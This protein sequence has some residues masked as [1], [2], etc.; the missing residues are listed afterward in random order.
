MQA[1]IEAV[2]GAIVVFGPALVCWILVRGF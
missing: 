2:I 1:F